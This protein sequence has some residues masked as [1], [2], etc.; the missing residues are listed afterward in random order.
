MPVP[1]FVL[2]LRSH[3]GHSPLWL[4][5][6]TAV[7]LRDSDALVVQRSDTR[8]WTPVTGI[9]DPGEQP[10]AAA[11]REVAEETGVRIEVERLAWVRAGEL[12]VHPNGDRVY[13]L[14]HLFRCRYLSGTAHVADDENV[15]VAWCPL[16]DL[17]AMDDIYRDRIAAALRED[18]TTRFDH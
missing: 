18:S 8:A 17:P 12:T 9:V 4:P 16:T 7:V 2:A 14:D 11:M 1:D 15:A 13:Y 5:G 3:V 10:A 6:V